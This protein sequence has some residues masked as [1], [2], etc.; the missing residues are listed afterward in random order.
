M[1]RRAVV[2]IGLLTLLVTA[3]AQAATFT[4]NS[5]TDPVGASG[6]TVTLCTIRTAIAAAAAN[7]S[8]T[9]DIVDIPAGT[10]TLTTG[11]GA[12]DG[13][14]V[15]DPDHH[16][17]RGREH[18]DRAGTGRQRHPRALASARAPA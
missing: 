6:C 18:D 7:G 5:T 2:L 13:S 9:D 8:T 4:V 3:P 11:L 16:Q 15:G 10:Y 14:R 12:L 1:Y 17:R